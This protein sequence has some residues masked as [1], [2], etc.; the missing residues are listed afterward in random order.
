MPLIRD[1]PIDNL[2]SPEIY[3]VQTVCQR[4]RI[5]EKDRTVATQ[6]SFNVYFPSS[7]TASPR[8]AGEEFLWDPQRFIVPGTKLSIE[9]VN[10]GSAVM[11]IIEE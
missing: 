11:S 8:E 4:V 1:F 3:T 5:R 7:S 2:G 6:A 9:S 10:V